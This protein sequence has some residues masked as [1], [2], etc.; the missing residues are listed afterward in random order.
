MRTLDPQQLTRHLDRLYRAAWALCGS[1]EEAEDLVQETYARVLAKPR[2]IRGES[3][4]HYL[5]RAL[6]NTFLSGRRTA[7]RRPATVPEPEDSPLPDPR[8]E[9][10]HQQALDLSELFAEIS[11]LPE[12]FRLAIVAVDVLGLSYAEAAKA[13]DTREATVTTRLHRARKRVVAALNGE[14]DEPAAAPSAAASATSAAAPAPPAA[15]PAAPL[16]REGSAAAGVIKGEAR[17]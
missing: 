7:A 8:A 3:D 11:R 14:S 13:L 4:L 17:T 5:L 10:R 2:V 9:G 1:R 15:P 16:P 6:R 12:D